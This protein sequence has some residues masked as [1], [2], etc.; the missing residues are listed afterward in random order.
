MPRRRVLLAVAGCF[1]VGLLAVVELSGALAGPFGVGPCASVSDGQEASDCNASLSRARAF[2]GLRLPHGAVRLSGEP[3]GDYG[4]LK[5]YSVETIT[6][7]RHVS[8]VWYHVPGTEAHLIAF[9]E[10]QQSKFGRTGWGMMGTGSGDTSLMFNSRLV[11]SFGADVEVDVT[12]L[13]GS[14]NG[15]LIESEV[16]VSCWPPGYK[17]VEGACSAVFP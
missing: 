4:F 11:G 3:R 13:R 17:G 2:L 6:G 7:T 15:V 5:P 16:G 9:I 10:A 8:H 12:N 1:C 14:G